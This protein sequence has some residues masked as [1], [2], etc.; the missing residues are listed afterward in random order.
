MRRSVAL[1]TLTCLLLL[2]LAPVAQAD[3]MSGGSPDILGAYGAAALILGF[4]GL[5]MRLRLLPFIP[6]HISRRLGPLAIAG[7]GLLMLVGGWQAARLTVP[8]DVDATEAFGKATTQ[9]LI[10]MTVIGLGAGALILRAAIKLGATSFGE[11]VKFRIFEVEDP[12]DPLAATPANPQSDRLA[13]VPLAVMAV[14][15]LLLTGG[16][17]LVVLRG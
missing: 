12:P 9:Q 8:H 14:L 16:V 2:A 13:L 6:A 15:A 7:G 11:T 3:H 17:L 4:S 10:G 5:L 1:F